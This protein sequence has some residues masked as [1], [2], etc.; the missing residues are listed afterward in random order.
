MDQ[1]VHL[2]L[3]APAVSSNVNIGRMANGLFVRLFYR[4][5]VELAEVNTIASYARIGRPMSVALAS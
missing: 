1:G 3:H 2:S 4:D 5:V